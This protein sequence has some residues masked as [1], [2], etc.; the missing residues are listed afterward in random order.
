MTKLHGILEHVYGFSPGLSGASFGS[1]GIGSTVGIVLSNIAL[2]RIHTR[3]RET[4]D[5]YPESRLI[6]AVIAAIMIPLSLTLYGF[7]AELKWP[8]ALL[9]SAAASLG[10]FFSLALASLTTYTTDSF[11]LYSASAMTSILTTRCVLGTFLPLLIA[12]FI[13]RYGYGRGLMM[14]A[15][16]ILGLAVIPMTIVL[17]GPIWRQRSRYT[18]SQQG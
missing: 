12:P 8:V 18:D 16:F 15:A 6:P 10:C 9:L 1:L 4:T 5:A 14:P 13:R 7:A 17:Y 11:G 2:D 3:L